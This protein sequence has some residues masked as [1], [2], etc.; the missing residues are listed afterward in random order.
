MYF[1]SKFIPSLFMPL[2]IAISAL[3]IIAFRK[4]N[5]TLLLTTLF[6]TFFSNG[7]VAELLNRVAEY[8]WKRL[9][10]NDIPSADA[11]V[12]LSQRRHKT[13]GKSD[14]IEWWDDPDRFMSGILLFKSNKASKL[15]FTGG[16]SPFYPELPPEGDLYK[17]EA[18]SFGLPQDKIY[19]TGIVKNTYEESEAVKILLSKERP[20]II[21]VTSAFHMN[22]A[23]NLFEKKSIEVIPYPVD[24]RST[25]R[26]GISKF[27]NP[28][29][30][31][32][33]AVHLGQ[34]SRIIREFIGRIIYK[35]I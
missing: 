11:V 21:L 14:I 33:N 26:L 28:T 8:P 7:F 35:L 13:P 9:S 19:T 6:L 5:Y 2:N 24:F 27:I 17:K 34:N 31:I 12:V 1:L 3:F 25:H 32:P 10:P 22:R 18:T 15:I 30:Y 4:K 16:Y 29:M 20:K 23:I